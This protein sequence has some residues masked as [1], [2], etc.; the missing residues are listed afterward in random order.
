MAQLLLS[1]GADPY[2]GKDSKGEMRSA[3]DV[4]MTK[5]PT[6]A[7]VLLNRGITC[8][9]QDLSSSNLLIIYDLEPFRRHFTSK[10]GE[11]SLHKKIVQRQLRELLKH[12]LSESFLQLKYHLIRPLFLI[13]L[14]LFFFFTFSISTLAMLATHIQNQC[15]LPG[16]SCLHNNGVSNTTLQS[17]NAFYAL[18]CMTAIAVLMRELLQGPD[19]IRKYCITIDL[20]L[21]SLSIEAPNFRL[22]C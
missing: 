17:F 21:F 6:A 8:N 14:F 18:T 15:Q 22:P 10:H 16:E 13:N 7:Q 11:M 2:I 19:S 4:F 5:N 20:C 9:D 12:P 3:F 1:Y